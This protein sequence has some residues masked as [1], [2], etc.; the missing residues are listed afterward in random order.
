MEHK[1]LFNVLITDE[2]GKELVNC[3]SDCIV[4]TISN[5]EEETDK[6]YALRT[7]CMTGCNAEKIVGAFRKISELK[8]EICAENEVLKKGF[9]LDALS[10]LTSLINN[11]LKEAK[12]NA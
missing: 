3:K 10:Q 7:I 1:Q 11:E 4:G 6:Q 8:D 2:N 12:G 5:V 9:T